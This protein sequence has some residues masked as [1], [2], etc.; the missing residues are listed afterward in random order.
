MHMDSISVV[1][2][3]FHTSDT[4][5]A[6][7]GAENEMWRCAHVIQ[8]AAQRETCLALFQLSRVAKRTTASSIQDPSRDPALVLHYN[9]GVPEA[10]WRVTRSPSENL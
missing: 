8:R 6:V 3:L 7:P 1:I 10:L 4:I 9:A 5:A 2:P